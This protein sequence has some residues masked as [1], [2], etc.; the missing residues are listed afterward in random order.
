MNHFLHDT[1]TTQEKSYPFP[2][3]IFPISHDASRT[4]T[5]RF[6]FHAQ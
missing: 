6:L 4:Y 2:L 3:S 1:F 5:Q